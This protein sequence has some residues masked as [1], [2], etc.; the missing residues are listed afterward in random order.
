MNNHNTNECRKQ[1][2]NEKQKDLKSIKC[3]KCK[4]TGHFAKNCTK[5]ES[6]NA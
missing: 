2:K 4:E 3:F 6:L 5:E 1:V